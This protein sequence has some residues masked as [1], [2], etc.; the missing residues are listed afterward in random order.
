MREWPIISTR[1]RN[2]AQQVRGGAA[3]LC[4][5]ECGAAIRGGSGSGLRRS[6][7]GGGEPAMR[8]CDVEREFPPNTV[9]AFSGE[10]CLRV[11]VDIIGHSRTKYVGKYQSCMV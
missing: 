3:G 2:L 5:E 1:T 7:G 8:W 6:S 9:L 4:R 10:S 11:R